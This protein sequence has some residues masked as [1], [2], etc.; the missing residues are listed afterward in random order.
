[1]DQEYR[2]GVGNAV[3][4]L[5]AVDFAGADRTLQVQVN[6]GNL[7]IILPPNVDAVVQADVSTGNAQVLGTSWGGLNQPPRTVTD[8]GGDGPGG[9]TL[10]VR[11]KVGIGNL[12]VRR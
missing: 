10:A 11:A 4:D 5:S 2:A 3:L 1:V 6:V 7:R 8:N 9:G 12:E